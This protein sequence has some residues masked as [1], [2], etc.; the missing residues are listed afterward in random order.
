MD[1]WGEGRGCFC[2]I[3]CAVHALCTT[4]STPTRASWLL[5]A[6][7][8]LPP[9]SLLPSPPLPPPQV[10]LTRGFQLIPA[11]EGAAINT[12]Q[13]V[14]AF[15][16]GTLI[17]GEPL[18]AMGVTGALAI[19]VGAVTVNARGTPGKD[20]KPTIGEAKYGAENGHASANDGI[21]GDAGGAEKREG[22][23]GRDIFLHS[24]R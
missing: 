7:P 19:V 11:G 17:L 24:N 12:I 6:S 22:G 15:V 3:T 9:P 4:L 1:G 18:T 16:Y 20:A 13:V 8:P 5:P 14:A 10:A 21:E 23:G 2:C